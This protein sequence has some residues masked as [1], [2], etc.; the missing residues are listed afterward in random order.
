M[1]LLHISKKILLFFIVLY[2]KTISPDH[3]W[4]RHRHPYGFC[5]FTPSCSEYGRQAIEKHG[6]VKGS[7]KAAWRVC[8]CHPWTSGGFDPVK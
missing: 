2:Q 7:A 4:R 8:R 6:A 3:G 1:W 5:P